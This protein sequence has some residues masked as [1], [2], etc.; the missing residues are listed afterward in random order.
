MKSTQS[1]ARQPSQPCSL[2]WGHSCPSS[3]LLMTPAKPSGFSVEMVCSSW[4]KRSPTCLLPKV[5]FVFP[6]YPIC[7]S[8]CPCL[9]GC[10]LVCDAPKLTIVPDSKANLLLFCCLSAF[11]NVL[12][13]IT[14]VDSCPRKEQMNHKLIYT[15]GFWVQ[16]GRSLGVH[17]PLYKESPPFPYSS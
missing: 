13:I 15:G 1:A 9:G 3:L 10:W 17:S 6:Q 4:D 7:P 14:P 12:H 8:Q 16:S 5:L 11:Q 2:S